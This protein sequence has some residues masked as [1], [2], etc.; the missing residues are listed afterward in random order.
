VLLQFERLVLMRSVYSTDRICFHTRRLETFVWSVLVSC[1]QDPLRLAPGKGSC[2]KEPPP[3]SRNRGG[4]QRYSALHPSSFISAPDSKIE[5]Q[6]RTWYQ[7]SESWYHGHVLPS[8]YYTSPSLPQ[9]RLLHKVTHHIGHGW[10]RIRKS[11]F[12]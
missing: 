5:V 11:T 3:L 4:N 10:L 2:L 1:K 6:T 7:R 9:N 8:I 12:S